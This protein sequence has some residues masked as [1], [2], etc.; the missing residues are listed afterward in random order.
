MAELVMPEPA[1]AQVATPN[2][3]AVRPH[4]MAVL[5]PADF[6]VFGLGVAIE[7]FARPRPELDI[8]WYDVTVCTAR[9]G[10]VRAMGGLFA[11]TIPH[12]LDAVESADTV[13]LPQAES[14]ARPAAPEALEAVRRAY[15]RGARLVSFCSGAFVLAAAGVLD[16]RR[17][18]TH[19]QYARALAA[20][21]PK[22]EVDADVLYI[23]DGQ[24][25]TSA[26]TAAGI[27]LSL[28][29]IRRDH[30]ARVARHVAR[31]LVMAPH[32]DGGQAQFVTTPV[33]DPTNMHDGVGQAME[34]ALANLDMDLDLAQLASIALMSSRNFSRRFREV[35]G[36]TPIKWL[37]NQRLAR[38]RELLEETDLSIER[39]AT[40]TG[41]GSVVT[42]RQRFA[43]E[44]LT[45][46][47]AYRR[48]FRSSP[49][50]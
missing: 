10:E 39:I 12:G 31:Q 16:G 6:T 1:L 23:D 11:A 45:S 37:S 25:L 36:T 27:D 8:D 20:R 22:V 38:V 2:L 28:H 34:Y 19:W 5:V 29:L 35:T 4:R 9:P 30:G 40:E 32:R 26:G 42:L 46:P 15:R 43:Q 21:Y 50:P 44:L 14:Y 18:T 17:A 41:H 33:P 48:S 13:V 7:V 47:T 24:I 3:Q 49:K